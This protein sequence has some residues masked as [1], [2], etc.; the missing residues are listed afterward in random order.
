MDALPAMIAYWDATL[1]CRYANRAYETWFGVTPEAMVGR[2][3]KA[4][5]GPLFELNRP[6]IEGALRGEPQQFEREI[7]DPHGGPAR[8]SQAHYIPDVVDGIVRG[9]SVLVADIT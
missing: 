2:E 8:F 5:L 4:F 1:H 6:F 7:P 9:F 3:M